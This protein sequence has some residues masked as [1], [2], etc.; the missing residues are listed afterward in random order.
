M[1]IS[2]STLAILKN[3][4]SIN[5][6][7]Q[8]RAGNVIKTRLQSKDL[9]A[10]ANI[11]G[12]MPVDFALLDLP[13][14]L[15]AVALFKEPQL[16]FDG[17]NAVRIHDGK[18]S[19]RYAF[20]DPQLVEKNVVVDYNRIPPS[21]ATIATFSL[22]WED[23]AKVKQASSVL[24]VPNITM[25]SNNG[26]LRLVAQDFNMKSSDNFSLVIGDCDVNFSANFKIETLK[27]I[28]DNYEVTITQQIATHFS[29]SKVNYMVAADIKA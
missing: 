24:S 4:A 22:A 28:P 19:V 23:L 5:P 7:I 1:K 10:T 29:G 3:F 6:S 26:E 8:F 11:D 25:V 13:R 20:T 9:M 14:F 16:D 12:E 15:G 27:L 17:D 18:N 21:P 2:E